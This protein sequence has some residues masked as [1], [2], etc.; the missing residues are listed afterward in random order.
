MKQEQLLTF[1]ALAA[2]PFLPIALGLAA[3]PD[4]LAGDFLVAVL[5]LA[6]GGAGASPVAASGLSSAFALGALVLE[7]V[8]FLVAPLF[9]PAALGLAATPDFLVGVFLVAVFLAA[10]TRE[11][12]Q[13]LCVATCTGGS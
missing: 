5:F 6:L 11:D 8:F 7:G 4:F 1:F 2:P 3:T 13:L 10:C 9:L 12:S